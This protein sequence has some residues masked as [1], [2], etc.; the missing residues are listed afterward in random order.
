MA[1][2]CKELKSNLLSNIVFL[3]LLLYHTRLKQSSLC[4]ASSPAI[5]G[6]ITANQL[7]KT[8]IQKINISDI[9]F[10]FQNPFLLLLFKRVFTSKSFNNSRILI[11][12]FGIYY[13]FVY[14]REFRILLLVCNCK[15]RCMHM[16]MDAWL[17]GSL[18]I[19]NCQWSMVNYKLRR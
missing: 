14:M 16:C 15:L 17:L 11:I 4:R 18:L 9:K 2:C 8:I 13:A 7:S 19:V 5:Y 10:S 3:T 12:L 6:E 1:A